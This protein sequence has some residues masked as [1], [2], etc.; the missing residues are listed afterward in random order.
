VTPPPAVNWTEYCTPTYD[1]N[2]N[3]IWAYNDATPAAYR[4]TGKS[5]CSATGLAG[6]C[7]V[8]PPPVETGHYCPYDGQS[9]ATWEEYNA[10][11]YYRLCQ[12]GLDPAAYPGCACPAGQYMYTTGASVNS[13]RGCAAPKNPTIS[14]TMPSGPTGYPYVTGTCYQPDYGYTITRTPAWA[15]GDAPE[16][17]YAWGKEDY[18]G[19]LIRNWSFADTAADVPLADGQSYTYTVQCTSLSGNVSRPASSTV[20]ALAKVKVTNVFSAPVPIT[21][22]GPNVATVTWKSTGNSCDLY[23][24]NTPQVKLNASPILATAGVFSYTLRSDAPQYRTELN[25]SHLGA[26]ALGY[27]IRCR[28]TANPGA[29]EARE[30]A[31]VQT[32]RKTEASLADAGDGSVLGKCTPDWKSM[33]LVNALNGRSTAA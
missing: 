22:A 15:A 17:A 11:C 27:E 26:G 7:N 25:A 18:Y 16:G 3:Q 13:S 32:Y 8:T 23:D 9:Y 6:I 1:G 2:P 28:D 10:F 29:A 5:C 21:A 30:L 20:G 4:F 31:R 19:N 24:M 33:K 12:N 14:A